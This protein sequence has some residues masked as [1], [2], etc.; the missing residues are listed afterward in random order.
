MKF[1]HRILGVGF[2]G[3]M[4]FSCGSENQSS[5]VKVSNGKVIGE[6]DYPSVVML[7]DKTKGAMCTGTFIDDSTVLTAAHCSMGGSVIDKSGK[8]DL[9][10]SYVRMIQG[11]EKKMEL[12]ANSVA[13]YRNPRWDGMSKLQPVNGL[14]LGIIKF[15]A[16]TAPATSKLRDRGAQKG[17]KVTIV[18]F[19][20]NYVPSGPSDMDPESAGIKRMGTNKVSGLMRGFIQFFGKG[21]TTDA[22]GNDANAS[23]G[24]SGG[25]LFIDGEL[26]GITSGGGKIF[27]KG[28]SLYV[29][30][31]SDSSKKFLGS[32]GY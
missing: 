13:V 29:D 1:A 8:V 15:P 17:D 5:N 7:Y 16:G 32:M 9:T 12:I 19:G 20:L 14:D 18:G 21:K 22:S 30:L 25:P 28:I 24:D 23:A 27:G 4:L 3:L 31:H 10:I 11:K 2:A 26:A 6:A